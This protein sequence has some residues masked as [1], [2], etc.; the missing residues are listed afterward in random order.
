MKGDEPELA[1][2]FYG[3]THCGLIKNDGGVHPIV[4]NWKTYFEGMMWNLEQ[5]LYQLKLDKSCLFCYR[6][7]CYAYRVHGVSHRRVIFIVGISNSFHSLCRDVLL[8][9]AKLETSSLYALFCQ[10]LELIHPVFIT[11]V[12]VWFWLL[13]S[14]REFRLNLSF[15]QCEDSLVRGLE[16]EYNVWD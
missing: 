2:Y 16:T 13:K 14:S 4:V 9:V 15:S 3:W 10:S 1:C 7:W 11:V 5:S 8:G 12:R 6:W